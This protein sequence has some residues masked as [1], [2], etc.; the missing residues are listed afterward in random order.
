M[1]R[2]EFYAVKF[3]VLSI[4]DGTGGSF[5]FFKNR[6]ADVTNLL[7]ANLTIT[8]VEATKPG[9]FTIHLSTDRVALFVWL[10][11]A[12]TSF[13]GIFPDNGF[14]MLT[15]NRSLTFETDS[16]SVDVKL[17]KTYLTE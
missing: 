7:P 13:H 1:T 10:D 16:P 6:L 12:T 8:G 14:H 3:C 11:I 9:V 17:L 5:L 4:G 2:C 15:P